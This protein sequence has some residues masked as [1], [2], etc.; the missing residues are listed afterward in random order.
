MHDG[1]LAVGLL[2]GECTFS[3]TL[4]LYLLVGKHFSSLNEVLLTDTKVGF[5]ISNS[6]HVVHD[7]C[8]DGLCFPF[9]SLWR[10]HEG[11]MIIVQLL[12]YVGLFGYR[13][14]SRVVGGGEGLLNFANTTIK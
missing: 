8:G 1:A 10:F 4:S 11:M 12:Q 5:L 7:E 13:D 6:F 2:T 14:S 9:I 3:F